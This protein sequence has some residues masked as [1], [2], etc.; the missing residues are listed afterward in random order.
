MW[1]KYDT[2]QSNY[3]DE[4]QFMLFAADQGLADLDTKEDAQIF[5]EMADTDKNGIITYDEFEVFLK[6]CYAG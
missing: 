1:K 4:K 6:K 3:L 2:D 5:I